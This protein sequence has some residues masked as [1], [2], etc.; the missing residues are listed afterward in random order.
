ML[1]YGFKVIFRKASY[2]G[3]SNSK[4]FFFSSLLETVAVMFYNT[5]EILEYIGVM[6]ETSF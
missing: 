4:S 6:N 2:L 1:F 3:N 5:A